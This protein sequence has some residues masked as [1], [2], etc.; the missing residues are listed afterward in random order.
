MPEVGR[1]TGRLRRCLAVVAATGLLLTGAGCSASQRGG[2]SPPSSVRP[3]PAT[4]SIPAGGV[5]LAGLG[6]QH[7]PIDALSLPRSVRIGTRV[8]Q[9]TA[10][11]L[12][13]TAPSAGTVAD[14]L[15]DAL[16]AGG[17]T[18]EER[19][20]TDETRTLTFA[21]HGWAGSFTGSGAESA[22]TLHPS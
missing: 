7:G 6:V 9:P 3:T 5:T 11:T 21:G 15:V 17:F 14:Y 16:P 4:P 20:G 19:A 10:V 22:L 12:V 8:D 2:Q 1:R 18:I 13:L